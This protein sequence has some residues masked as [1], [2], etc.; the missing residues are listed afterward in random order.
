V[1]AVAAPRGSTPP[2]K[3]GDSSLGKALFVGGI[4]LLIV[5]AD[6][7]TKLWIDHT[8]K[9]HET[10]P[11][12]PGWVEIT[13]VRNTGAAFSML[14]GRSAA[15]RVPFFTVAFL[16]AGAAIIGFIRQTPASQRLVLL[17]CSFVLGGAVGNLIDRLAHGEV[18]DF[19]LVH[20]RDWYWPAFNVADSFISIGVVFLLGRALF[21]RD[22]DASGDKE[23]AGDA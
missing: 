21:A 3:G 15:F 17:A 9:L 12:V 11:I 14:A 19:V 4:A 13:Y 20:Y 6:Q 5:L 8:M 10:I 23:S 18:I 2:Q 1:S 22:E 7:A 16:L